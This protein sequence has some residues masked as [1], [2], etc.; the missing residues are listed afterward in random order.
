MVMNSR[1]MRLLGIHHWTI[2][3]FWATTSGWYSRMNN[4]CGGDL[5]AEFSAVP[6][7]KNAEIDW[8]S[9]GK[10]KFNLE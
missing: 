10:V 2:E 5:R 9:F 4:N 6:L 8:E 1:W 7:V 3:Q